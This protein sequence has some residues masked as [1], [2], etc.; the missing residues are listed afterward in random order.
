MRK[1]KT[2]TITVT[3]ENDNTG[4]IK[5][6]N[7]GFSYLE[8]VGLLKHTLEDVMQNHKE[9]KPPIERIYRKNNS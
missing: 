2:Y 5:R 9:G 1:I 8:L 4:S 6:E 7:D 3:Q